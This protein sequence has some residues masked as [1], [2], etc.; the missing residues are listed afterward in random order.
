MIFNDI[1]QQ[2]KN[3]LQSAFSSS[4]EVYSPYTE[5]GIWMSQCYPGLSG[6]VRLK[7]Q[8]VIVIFVDEFVPSSALAVH[9]TA[10]DTIDTIE[11]KPWVVH[12]QNQLYGWQ[13][14]CSLNE[15]PSFNE[16]PLVAFIKWKPGSLRHAIDAHDEMYIRKP[17]QEDELLVGSDYE[18]E[19]ISRLHL[20]T[21]VSSISHV[22]ARQGVITAL[23][24]RMGLELA[25]TLP[26][27]AAGIALPAVEV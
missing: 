21:G 25:L 7:H 27:A 5:A 10:P 17:Y 6:I 18:K 3:G 20:A 2:A 26:Y 14:P 16:T 24:K 19:S 9:L 23:S 12:V 11:P 8:D 15:A 13:F 1:D 4:G 22:L